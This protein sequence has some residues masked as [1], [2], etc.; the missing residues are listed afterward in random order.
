MH[1]R[2]TEKLATVIYKMNRK[3]TI[4]MRADASHG[5]TMTGSK[6]AELKPNFLKQ[7]HITGGK[8][9]RFLY[10]SYNR[11]NAS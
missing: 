4:L 3:T 2:M 10:V 11:T 8:L 7:V 9:E 1:R 6:H 5:Y